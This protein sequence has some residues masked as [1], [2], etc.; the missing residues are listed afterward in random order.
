[1]LW[2]IFFAQWRKTTVM[3]IG[4][5]GLF[6]TCVFLFALNHQ[7]A[8]DA[9]LVLPLALLL[10]VSIVIQSGFTPAALAHLADITEDHAQ[11]RGAIMGMYSVFLGIGQFLGA[12]IGGP[13]VDWR[14]A[15]G[16]VVVTALLGIVSTATLLRLHL[17][18]AHN[19]LSQSA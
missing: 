11:D 13:F 8:L 9:P 15:D 5:G 3:L 14:G 2:S 12:T 17:T 6:L 4:T 10:V 1:L 16:I 7:P 19:T 18:Q